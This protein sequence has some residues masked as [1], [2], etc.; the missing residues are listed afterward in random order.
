M[1]KKVKNKKGKGIL[2]DFKFYIKLY[3]TSEQV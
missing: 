2:Y 3:L 1:V